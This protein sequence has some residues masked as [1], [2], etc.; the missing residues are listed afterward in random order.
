MKKKR[1]S[2]WI[3]VILTGITTTAFAGNKSVASDK[4]S[5]VIV[6]RVH[7]V[8]DQ[9]AEQASTIFAETLKDMHGKLEYGENPKFGA[10]FLH[11]STDSLSKPNYYKQMWARDC[12]RGVMELARL[13]FSD[14]AK[15]VARYF[16]KHI[17]LKDHWGR[18]I[19]RPYIA[20][21]A[22]ELDGNAW[23]LSA[24]CSAWQV[25]ERDKELGKEFCRGISPVVG[26][27]DSL[28]TVSP[29]GGLLPSISEL[30]GNPSVKYTVY[31]IFGNYGM[32]VALE[33]IAEMAEASGETEVAE[34]VRRMHGKL[35]SAISSL[36]SDGKFSYAPKGCWFNGFDSRTGT[37]YDLS[38]WDGTAW[39]IWHWT[40]QLPYIQDYDAG[41]SS[42]CGR[43][44]DVHNASYALLRHWMAKG[45]Y[46]RKYGFVSNSGWTGMG[47][48]H[49]ETM[50]GYGQGFFTQAA[51]MAD[52]VNTY[53][54]CLEGIAR[55]GYDGGVVEQMSYERNPFVMNEC[56]N[57]DNYESGLDHT[58]GTHKNGRREIMENPSDE[59]N[60]VQES[61]VL[62]AFRL[63]V[64]VECKDGNLVIKPRLPWLWNEMECRDYPVIDEDGNVRRVDISFRHE[65]WLGKCS[66]EIKGAEKFNAVDVRFGPFPEMKEAPE[67]FVLETTGNASWL[68]A[69]NRKNA[70][71]GISVEIPFR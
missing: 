26:W 21:N 7:F 38:D 50:C 67:G 28:I 32:Y 46:F 52:D 55:L 61:E 37:A 6:P 53:S 10:G 68:W 9:F 69:R 47:E 54:K 20:H 25:N 27:V 57:Y 23:I 45:E 40:R 13:G 66:V 11:T 65:R 5:D 63:V 8:G 44:A 51:L 64:G 49:D 19:H 43:F 17:N 16:L 4:A 60:L 59:G 14:D 22:A 2:L 1:L 36:V 31:S 56:F 62:K 15:L 48:R 58:F 3:A 71:K 18:E 39:P 70:S 34:N 41:R 30:S 35:E 24:I 42:I 12:G 29:Y 33:M